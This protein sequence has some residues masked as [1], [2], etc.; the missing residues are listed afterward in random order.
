MEREEQF[1]ISPQNQGAWKDDPGHVHE[2]QGLQQ[3]REQEQR[4]QTREQEDLQAE[5]KVFSVQEII[6]KL[7]TGQP[8]E[9]STKKD[10]TKYEKC[11]Y[12]AVA[13]RYIAD[14]EKPRKPMRYDDNREL[15]DMVP[16]HDP[17]EYPQVEKISKFR[18]LEM[19]YR[20]T[21]SIQ[22]YDEEPLRKQQIQETLID[23]DIK[24]MDDTDVTSID[25]DTDS[26]GS[27]DNDNSW[28]KDTGLTPQESLRRLKPLG[29]KRVAQIHAIIDKKL[30]QK[31]SGG[32]DS[33]MEDISSYCL[34]KEK[35][36][37][38]SK[39]QKI[40]STLRARYEPTRRIQAEEHENPS[41]RKVA[42]SGKRREP[43]DI[44]KNESD[45]DDSTPLGSEESSDNESVDTQ[46]DLSELP[47]DDVTKFVDDDHI[48][49]VAPVNKQD[50]DLEAKETVPDEAKADAEYYDIEDEM[51]RETEEEGR[52]EIQKEIEEREKEEL[53]RN[54][55][56]I[57]ELEEKL[58][59]LE[60]PVRDAVKKLLQVSSR[61][62]KIRLFS[63]ERKIN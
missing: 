51:S 63:S 31:K 54:E 26:G 36:T 17:S 9:V 20:N 62:N 47:H 46:K 56:K 43:T 7:N 32:R 28:D 25:S 27:A 33:P 19:I 14:S 57:R 61:V 52:S 11:P 6:Q 1:I 39:T 15:E 23:D 40:P 35:R 42:S 45:E 53:L 29:E 5:E 12:T 34:S 58:A 18:E 8:L 3:F 4:Q 44:R 37:L 16:Y 21:S 50:P 49:A 48:E 22:E 10:A 60:A 41:E 24:F 13:K 2:Q 59:K 30:G 55:Q 38:L